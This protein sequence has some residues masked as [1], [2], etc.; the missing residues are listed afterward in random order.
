MDKYSDFSEE[1]AYDLRVT[2]AKIVGDH[3]I[4]ISLVRRKKDY[5]KYFEA[6]ENL[7]TVV[8]HKI[9]VEANNKNENKDTY[10]E[11]KRQAVIILNKHKNVYAG[12]SH[13]PL[14]VNEV[15]QALMRIERY[16]YKVIDG[17]NMFGKKWDDDGL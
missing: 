3:L 10:E 15:S 12:N 9:E 17:A 5:P 14:G 11:L 2:Y 6:L 16:L 4:D 8:S 13:D 7:Y 1:L